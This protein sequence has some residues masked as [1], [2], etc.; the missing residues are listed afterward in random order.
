[1][2]TRKANT[3]T[4]KIQRRNRRGNGQ[5][6]QVEKFAGDAYSLGARALAGVQKLARLINIESKYFS[7]YTS[8]NITQAP[9]ISCQSLVPQGVTQGNR[10]GESIKLQSLTFQYCVT[11]HVSDDHEICRV[12]LVRDLE[13]HGA[14]FVAA[15]LLTLATAAYVSDIVFANKDRFS[16]IYDKVFTQTTGNNDI[17]YDSFSRPM[18]SHIMYRAAATSSTSNAEGALYLVLASTATANW[19]VFEGNLSFTFT[20]D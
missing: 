2:S 18:Q 15:E 6:R 13:N 7:K 11:L 12:M 8:T 9:I 4:G 10:V 17:F 16:I 3:G 14:D 19:P 20:D 1:M 5:R